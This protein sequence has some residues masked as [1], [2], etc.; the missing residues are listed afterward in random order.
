MRESEWKHFVTSEER[1]STIM[2]I[3]NHD[4]SNS[5]SKGR[6]DIRYNI[7]K[8]EYFCLLELFRLDRF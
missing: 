1:I 2:T 6:D 4:R 7:N 3:V 5:N 8:I